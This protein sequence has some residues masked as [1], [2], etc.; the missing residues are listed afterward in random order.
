YLNTS[1][2]QHLNTLKPQLQ[3]TNTLPANRVF[4]DVQRLPEPNG[5]RRIDDGVEIIFMNVAVRFVKETRHHTAIRLD[6]G[7]YPRRIAYRFRERSISIDSM[8][9]AGNAHDLF[10][11]FHNEA[12]I[13]IFFQH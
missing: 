6:H 4:S 5:L 11:A 12:G 8:V 10:R 2:P 13:V 3:R 1:T 7:R 9:I